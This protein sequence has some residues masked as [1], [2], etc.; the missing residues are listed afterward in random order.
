[1]RQRG[2]VQILLS[3][4]CF[5]FLGVF[6]KTAYAQGLTPGVFLGF[7]F[8]LAA[9]L[10]A[11]VLSIRSPQ[12]LR[13]GRRSAL[14]A[15]LLGVFGYALFSSCYFFALQGLSVSLTVLLLYTYPIWVTVGARVFFREHLAPRQWAALPIVIG[16]LLLLLWGELRAREPFS[17]VLG[18]LSSIFYANYI[19]CSRRWLKAVPPLGSAFYVMLGAG[20]VMAALNIRSLPENPSVWFVLFGT[21]VI[22]TIFAISLFLAGLQKLTGAE[23]SMLS[24]AEPVTAVFLGVIVFGEVLLPVQWA[25]AVLIAGGMMLVASAQRSS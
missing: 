23:A 10:L 17:L 3:G 7:R 12:T 22:S 19:L 14:T 24:L 16:G 13:I 6:G 9:M 5:G 1:M 11:L 20:C 8:M 21:S 4:F 25:G 15:F 18:L 2:I